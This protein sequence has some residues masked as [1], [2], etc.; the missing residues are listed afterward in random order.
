MLCL[1]R[2][3]IRKLHPEI[4][5]QPFPRSIEKLTGRLPQPYSA[6]AI[7]IPIRFQK[8]H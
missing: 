7:Y 6:V 2:T 8:K 3:G 1:R 5:I 4:L